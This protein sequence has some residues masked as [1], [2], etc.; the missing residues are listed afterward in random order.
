MKRGYLLFVLIIGIFL[1]SG[2]P[3]QEQITK[4][5]NQQPIVNACIQACKDAQTAGKDLAAGPCLMDPASQD[6]DWVCDIAHDPRQQI[7]NIQE[8]Q[9]RAY[10]DGMA[11]HFIEVTPTCEIMRIV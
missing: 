11:H 2:C 10:R 5:A 6:N 3:K 1:V 7:D 4:A 9:C 8:N